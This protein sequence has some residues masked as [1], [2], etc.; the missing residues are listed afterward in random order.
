MSGQRPAG[1]HRR[2]ESF[3]R[4]AEQLCLWRLRLGG[5]RILARR[6]ATPVGEIDIVARRGG[7]VAVIEVKARAR[8]E[9]A[10]FALTPRQCRRIERASAALLAR[11]PALG[12]CALRY[13]LMLVR[14]WRL[15]V[16]WPDAWRPA[17]RRGDAES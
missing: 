2:A 13:D 7:T 11:Y 9:A 16:H 1:R 6:F 14:P 3:G 17:W 5:Y 12:Q 10:A 4:L 15:P 8:L